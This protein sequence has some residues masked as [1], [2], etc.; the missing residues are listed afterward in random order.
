[1]PRKDTSKRKTRLRLVTAA[2][3]AES[4]RLE[5]HLP[6]GWR[7]GD[8]TVAIPVE[9]DIFAYAGLYAGDVAVAVE[10]ADVTPDD[11]AYVR[12]DGDPWLGQYRPGPGGYFTFDMGGDVRRFRPGAAQLLGRVCHFE[13]RGEV[14]RRFRSIR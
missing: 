3:R 13:S 11:L 4:D 5:V 1:M 9:T 2:P 6:V 12:I 8:K 10:T 14:I 7:R